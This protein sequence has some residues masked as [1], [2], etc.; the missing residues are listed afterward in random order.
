MSL[1]SEAVGLLRFIE[2]RIKNL[3]TG[4]ESDWVESDAAAKAAGVDVNDLKKVLR[5]PR[6]KTLLKNAGLGCSHRGKFIFVFKQAG[7]GTST[8]N[9]DDIPEDEDED[10][11]VPATPADPT[12]WS[13]DPNY[14]WLPPVA[15]DIDIAIDAGKNIFAVG[16]AGSGKSSMIE[17]VFL[18]RG[19]KPMT[20]SFHGEVSA[21]DLIGGKDLVNGQTI[22]TD[23]ILPICMRKG[24]PL[25]IDEA[26]ATP[27]DVQFVLHPVLMGQPLLLTRNGAEYVNPEPGFLIAATGNTVGRGDDSGL[28]VGTNVLN[29][30]YLDRYGMVF[31]HWYM[32]KDEEVKVLVKRT[33]IHKR[34][35]VKMVEVAESARNAMIA[36]HLSS[37]FSTRKL[38][39][40]C[41]LTVRGMDIGKA[42]LYSCIGK[43]SK[44]DRRAIAEFGLATFGSTL[45]VDPSKF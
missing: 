24:V 30:A 16:P 37:T 22:W 1:K 31:D 33:G 32:P 42:F 21:Y 35:A 29:E 25:I 12:D 11:T 44:E 17:R 2:E 34:M 9:E 28:Y 41:D 27:P 23:G 15:A 19:V 39:D 40:W 43:V 10:T 36:D 20:I 8:V 3:P 13:L 6:V 38:L 18:N 14:F 26:D 5:R 7:F 4:K 45:G